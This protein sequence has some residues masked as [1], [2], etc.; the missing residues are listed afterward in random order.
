MSVRKQKR[1]RA[2]G[3]IL[4]V[5]YIVFIFYFLLI[6]EVYGRTG[7]VGEYHY[8]LELFR[9]IKRFWTYREQLGW[10]ATFTNLAGNVLVF[11]PFGF[12]MS[13]ASNYRSF[14]NTTFYSFVLSLVV[15]LSQLMM[16]VGAFDVDDLLLNTAGGMLGYICFLICNAI[17]RNYAKKK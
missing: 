16:R 6:S 11:V 17:R 12:L 15:E 1:Y 14:L 2:L 4:F 5:L 3:K 7:D 13:M 10:F 9:E 8:N